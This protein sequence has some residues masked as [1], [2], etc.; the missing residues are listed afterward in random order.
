M[1]WDIIQGLLTQQQRQKYESIFSR[2]FCLSSWQVSLIN[3]LLNNEITYPSIPLF[4]RLNHLPTCCKF[5]Q[6]ES[7][8]N[9]L[10]HQLPCPPFSY[11]L[12]YG[13]SMLPQW[14]SGAPGPPLR[15]K[16]CK[17]CQGKG[18]SYNKLF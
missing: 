13:G 2:S 4:S 12:L 7:S 18:V 9:L 14:S 11:F 8:V 17:S 15:K 3:P 10:S 5:V 16:R 1:K 6:G